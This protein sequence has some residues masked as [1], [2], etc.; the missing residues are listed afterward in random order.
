LLG[1]RRHRNIIPWDY[2]ADICMLSEDYARLRAL[3]ER[4]GGVIG[5]LRLEADDY[6]ES[7]TCYAF[8][9]CTDPNLLIDVVAYR[10]E[11]GRL[12]NLMS[13]KLIAEYPGAYDS[14]TE[15]IFP[16]RRGWFLGRRVLVP[17]QTEARLV[18]AFGHGWRDYPE[19]YTD[20]DVT[21]PPFQEIPTINLSQSDAISNTALPCIWR[22]VIPSGATHYHTADALSQAHGGRWYKHSEGTDIVW[23]IT[24]AALASLQ[25]PAEL[26][27]LSFTDLVFMEERK[28]WGEICVGVLQQGDTLVLPDGCWVTADTEER[29]CGA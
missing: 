19:G 22:G 3:F 2:D 21:A 29:G 27:G 10:V 9:G 24:P 4:H 23:V 7:D 15:V 12:L 8:V 28:L 26:A 6:G 16:L 11:A 14:T 1:Y 18:E 17:Q 25:S 20:S 13:A 5:T